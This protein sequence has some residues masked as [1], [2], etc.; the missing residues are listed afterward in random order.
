MTRLSSSVATMARALV[1]NSATQM[2]ASNEKNTKRIVMRARF[3]ATK[4]I[5]PSAKTMPPTSARLAVRVPGGRAVAE[6][7]GEATS[8]AIALRNVGSGLA[9]LDRWDFYPERQ[10]GEVSY[11]DPSGFHRLTRDI[12]VPAGDMGFWQG[13][14]REPSDPN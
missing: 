3:C 5:T 2:R 14:F 4:S 1:I 8:L 10:T 7:A 6:V 11:R 13:A 12:Y 9:V